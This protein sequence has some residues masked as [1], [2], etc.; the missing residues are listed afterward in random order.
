MAWRIVSIENPAH[1]SFKDNKLV[2]SQDEEVNVPLEDIDTLV[3]NGQGITLTQ[4]LLAELANNKVCTI[5]C[6]GKHLPSAVIEPYSQASRGVKTAKAQ[7][8][9]SESTRKHLWRRNIIAK[10]QNQA[11]VLKKHN[12]PRDDLVELAKNVRSG[13]AGNAES[14]A[15]RLY[16]A[17]LLEDSTRRKPM[18]HNSALDYGYAIVRSNI[19]RSVAARGLIAM[20]GINHRSE[21]NQYN[22]VDDLIESFRPFVDDYIMSA[23][24]ARHIGDFDDDNLTRED[25]HLIIDILNQYGIIDNKKYQIKNLCDIVVENFANAVLADDAEPFVLPSIIK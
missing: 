21:L 22:L 9:I 16:F 14:I 2:I 6:D 7:L 23:V 12:L 5:I 18:W 25:R 10:I 1:L 17:R 4:N 13:D 15:A 3:L 19:A 11:D 24:A 20:I 8:G